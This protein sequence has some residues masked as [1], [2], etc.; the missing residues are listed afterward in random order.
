MEGLI[1]VKKRVITGA[2]LIALII[3]I[4]WINI[5]LVDTIFI[6]LISLM[7]MYEYNKAFKSAGYNVVPIVGY[8]SCFSILLMGLNIPTDITILISR[9]AIPSVLIVT[10]IYS[11]LS[12]LKITII[13]VAITILS[14]VYIP[15]LFS[16]LKLILMMEHGRLFIWF[17]IMGAFACDTF[18]F[19][20]G[21]K[22][23]KRKLCPEVSP[24]K[25][26]EGS[27]A[28]IL[29]VVITYIIIYVIARFCLNIYL[30]IW[31]LMLMAIISG[32]IG[33]FGD[34]AASSIKRFCNI[35][36]FGL[37]MPGHGGILDRC[38]SIMFVA[39]IVYMILKVYMFM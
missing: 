25:T 5:P 11:I 30:N 13:D 6:L 19:L 12:K 36:D 35:K 27:I 14:I 7:G 39:P 8:I 37:I 17:V 31:I 22:F 23:G 21:C 38:D 9:I 29:G 2:V 3:L 18:A 28:G 1:L 4:L 32:I 26:I 33:Q 10:F 16:F 34:L 15:F 20:I 24:K